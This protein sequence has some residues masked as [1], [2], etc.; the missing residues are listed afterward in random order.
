MAPRT[1]YN[2]GAS[3]IRIGFGAQDTIIIKRSPQN[4]IGNYLAPYSIVVLESESQFDSRNEPHLQTS[5]P[6]FCP[7]HF[8]TACACRF[9]SGPASAMPSYDLAALT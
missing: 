3:I 2:I 8:A 9:A 1:L 7:S 5:K 4:S 6:H